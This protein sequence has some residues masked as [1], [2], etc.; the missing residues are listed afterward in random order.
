MKDFGM[1]GRM[2]GLDDMKGR[3]TVFARFTL[4]KELRRAL[5]ETKLYWDREWKGCGG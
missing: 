1:D 4:S 5:P 2:G 3:G